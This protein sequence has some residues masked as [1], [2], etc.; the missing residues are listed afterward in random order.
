[1]LIGKHMQQ[2]FVKDQKQQ[3]K[4][5]NNNRIH[6]Q[7]YLGQYYLTHQVVTVRVALAGAVLAV[8][9]VEL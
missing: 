2:M 4:E 7:D 8:L 9:Q 3:H 5:M 1:M 6:F